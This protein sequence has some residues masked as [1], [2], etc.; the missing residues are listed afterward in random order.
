MATFLATPACLDSH[1]ADGVRAQMSKE[2]PGKFIQEGTVTLRDGEETR[3]IYKVPYLSPPRL[4]I[5]K[6]EQSWFKQVPF[7]LSDFKFLQQEALFFRIQNNHVERQDGAW[8]VLKWRAEGTRAPDT[9]MSRSVTRE[10]LVAAVEKLNGKITADPI[11]PDKPVILIDL[12]KT[13]ITDAD[14]VALQRVPSLRTLNLH[15][16]S[17]SDAGL[18][19]VSGLTGLLVLHLSDTAVTDAGLQHLKRLTNL[20]ELG[21]ANTK[22]TDEG[23]IALR[24]LS[25]LQI[26]A[27]SGTHISDRGLQNLK[28]LS[29]LKQVFLS[30]TSVT[31]AGIQ[32]LQRALPKV[33]VFK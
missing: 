20:R 33:H 2:S 21:L 12:H 4:T 5:V 24:G 26:L 1:W 27:L 10:Q 11:P 16:T 15:G 7:K 19:Y 18:A 6:F 22:I 23:L 3:I 8:A 31:A 25:N 17:I 32:E 30:H 29:N 14:L 9:P 28:G 13:G